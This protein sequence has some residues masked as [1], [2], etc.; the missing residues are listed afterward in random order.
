M[1]PHFNKK[2][3]NTNLTSLSITDAKSFINN[4]HQLN[5]ID[6]DLYDYLLRKCKL[7]T[8]TLWNLTATTPLPVRTKRT[9][10]FTSPTNNNRKRL[11]N[12]KTIN[13]LRDQTKS[14]KELNKKKNLRKYSLGSLDALINNNCS[15]SN[16]SNSSKNFINI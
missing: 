14:N 16:V 7:S 10:F 8:F 13:I 12:R 11:N 9:A 4:D 6:L 15:N 2:T 3:C 5:C 1:R